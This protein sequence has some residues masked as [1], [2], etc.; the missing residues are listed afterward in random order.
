MPTP[1]ETRYF[2]FREKLERAIVSKWAGNVRC[3]DTFAAAKFLVSHAVSVGNGQREIA[4][5]AWS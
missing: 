2:F 1:R 5:R 4:A 3:P